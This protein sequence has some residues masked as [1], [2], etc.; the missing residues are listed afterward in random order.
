MKRVIEVAQSLTVLNVVFAV[1]LV[2]ADWPQFRGP[3]GAGASD[4]TG[5]PVTWSDTENL[6]WRTPLPG[7]GTSSPITAGNRVFLT[8][9]T[10]Y[11][12]DASAPGNMDDLRLHVLCVGLG[13]GKILWD[14]EVQPKLPEQPYKSVMNLHGYASSTPAADS[15]RVYAFF[16]KSDVVA[17]D[18]DGR[19]LWR[20]DVGS[21]VC[22]WGTA[23][24]VVLHGELVIVNAAI[25]S[26]ALVALNKVDGKEVWR[27]DRIRRTWN[28]PALV[29]AP[30]GKRELVLAIDG[31]LLGFEP[32]TGERLWT[33]GGL[34][35]YVSPSVVSH[36]GIVYAVGRGRIAVAVRAG[37]R[38][39]VTGSHLLWK[40]AKGSN[41]PSPVYHDGHLY[42][43]EAGHGV[44]HC[45]NATTGEVVYTE[46][47]RPRPGA[48]YASPVVADGKLYYVSR[49]DGVYV[50]A[51]A[52]QFNLLA[53]NTFAAD[54]S[55]SN[56]SLA[57]V[58]GRLLLRSDKFLYRIGDR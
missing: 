19:E 51:A 26:G 41:V 16:G 6:L 20:V 44:L 23:A 14:R 42:F 9:Y 55:L 34:R 38:G 53:H 29:E 5:L 3:G 27:A 49:G 57:A 32:A 48:I 25:E 1:S 2:G 12:L 24:S 13:D 45:L 30:A 47:L 39:D 15:E 52:L 10:G 35:G 33:C 31:Q 11:G 56:A 40:T 8:C 18:H 37:G 17:F 36:D 28:T 54:A 46:R 50:V 4:E 21:R 7:P 22:G 43:A 58:D